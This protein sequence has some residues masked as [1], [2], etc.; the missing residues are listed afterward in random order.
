LNGQF[1][2]SENKARAYFGAK[3]G[4]AYQN[5]VNYLRK[6]KGLCVDDPKIDCRVVS[7]SL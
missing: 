3:A 1:E 7:T 2:A 6:C 4:E 5:V